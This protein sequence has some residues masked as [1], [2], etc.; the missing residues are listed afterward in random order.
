[1][2]ARYLLI[3]DGLAHK[4]LQLPP[5][6]LLALVQD[7]AFM[8][9]SRFVRRKERAVGDRGSGHGRWGIVF[10]FHVARW[11]RFFRC[12]LAASNFRSR[13]ARISC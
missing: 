8:W 9:H 1:M 12:S 10:S 11:R 3:R 13:S 6:P 5:L 2:S 7:I 4:R